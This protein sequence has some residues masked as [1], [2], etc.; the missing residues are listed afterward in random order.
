MHAKINWRLKSKKKKI[1]II[2]II[3]NKDTP[4][5]MSKCPL[6]EVQSFISWKTF[7]DIKKVYWNTHPKN[8]CLAMSG[9]V[10]I[11]DFR[12]TLNITV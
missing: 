7:G 1:I 11:L 3:T 5:S 10:A 8:V 2:I 4:I 6:C 12:L 9:P